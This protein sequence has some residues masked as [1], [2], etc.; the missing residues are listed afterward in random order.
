MSL[1]PITKELL[2][3]WSAEQLKQEMKNPERLAQI[4]TFLTSRD[5]VALVQDIAAEPVSDEPTEEIVVQLDPQP[6]VVH[7]STAEEDQAEIDKL[8]AEQ[9][10]RA[11]VEARQEPPRKIVVEYQAK[12]EAGNPIGRPTHL[13]AYSWEEMSK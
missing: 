7:Q 1:E 6:V 2:R 12:D 11:A 3:S 9:V 4:N 13:E 8:H 5:A 10:E